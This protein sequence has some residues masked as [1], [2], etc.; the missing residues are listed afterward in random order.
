MHA[1]DVELLEQI[2]AGGFEP[3]TA[4]LSPFDNLIC[5]RNRTLALWGFDFKL[6]INVPKSKRWVTS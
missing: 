1:E 5:D 6:E 2:D 4:L 3:R